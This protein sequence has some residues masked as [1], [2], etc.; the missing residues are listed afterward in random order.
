MTDILVIVLRKI[1]KYPSFPNSCQGNRVCNILTVWLWNGSVFVNNLLC[2]LQTNIRKFTACRKHCFRPSWL[3]RFFF[4]KI[5]PIVISSY[6]FSILR[7]C[8]GLDDLIDQFKLTC[9][10]WSNEGKYSRFIW[11]S[12][13]SVQHLRIIRNV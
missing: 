12:W 11:R 8:C 10:L 5:I 13:S 6:R 4:T 3:I 2:W 9:P 7:L 1:S